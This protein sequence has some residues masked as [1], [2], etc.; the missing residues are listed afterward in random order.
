[1]AMLYQPAAHLP[2]SAGEGKDELIYCSTDESCRVQSVEMGVAVGGE[3]SPL[4][5]VVACEAAENGRAAAEQLPFSKELITF[6]LFGEMPPKGS[7][8]HVHAC[9][10]AA[11]LAEGSLTSIVAECQWKASLNAH[12]EEV[13]QTFKNIPQMLYFSPSSVALSGIGVYAA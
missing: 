8:L 11:D 1:M 2:A 9:M 7:K 4:Q 10:V 6:T 5:E 13:Q 12:M 3:G